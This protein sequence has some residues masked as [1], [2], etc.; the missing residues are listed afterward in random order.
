MTRASM[1][2]L[3]RR[4][5]RDTASVDWQNDSDL[6]DILNMAYT[7]V[8]KTI[9]KSFPEA[10]LSWDRLDLVS[11]RSW[12]PLPEHF[13]VSHV[14]I[15]YSSADT[16]WTPLENGAYTDI[17]LAT[18]TPAKFTRKGQWIGIF[19]APSA[20]I[21]DGLEV[22]HTPIM[23]LG[24]DTEV[25]KIKVPLH[26]A[27]VLWAKLICLGETDETAGETRMRIQEIMDDLPNWYDI[28]NYA[29]EQF[30]VTA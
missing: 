6:D 5:I 18:S 1:R 8:Q 20:N 29:P 9:M 12:Y 15:K 16:V 28:N 11:G 26:L 13:G 2:T 24:S 19:P 7:L 30:Q 21:T 3:L 10:H 17:Y 27:I 23:T 4:E 14:A 22:L 25:P